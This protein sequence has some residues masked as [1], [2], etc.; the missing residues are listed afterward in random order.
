MRFHRYYR[1]HGVTRPLPDDLLRYP[2]LDPVV[3]QT[4]RQSSYRPGN[5]VARVK[6]VRIEDNCAQE[7]RLSVVI[8]C[9]GFATIGTLCHQLNLPIL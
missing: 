4:L 1:F 3:L 6:G 7:N 5:E 2:Q 8:L 9:S